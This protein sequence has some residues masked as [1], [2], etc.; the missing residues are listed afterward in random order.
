MSKA[1]SMNL[2]LSYLVY[3]D[4]FSLFLLLTSK[5]SHKIKMS[6]RFEIGRVFF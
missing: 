4:S 3:S 6:V 5:P 2:N 1:V